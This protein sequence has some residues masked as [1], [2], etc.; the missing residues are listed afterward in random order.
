MREQ[1]NFSPN[2]GTQ[3]EIC[4]IKVIGVGGAGG[5]AVKS[6][7]TEGIVGV[8]FLIC[9]TDK[10]AL[11]SNPVPNKLVLG[12]T[13][14]GAGAK[15]EVACQYAEESIDEIKKLIGDDTKMLFITA[16]MGKGT[17]TGAT[18]VIAKV[19]KEMGILT[20]GVV[21]SPYTWEGRKMLERAENGIAE[22]KKYVDSIIV[23]NNQNIL[24][25]YPDDD[26]PTAYLRVDNVLKTAVK[27][28]AELITV[29]LEQ[30]IDF[31]DIKTIL[32]GSGAAMMGIGESNSEN[33]MEEVFTEAFDCPLL[34]QDKVANARKFL[35]C[36][37][38]GPDRPAKMSE[39]GDLTSRF[40]ELL[41]K[42]VDLIWGRTEDPALGDKVKLSVII[43]DY[44]A[45]TE[46]IKTTD[47]T[48]TQTQEVV[49]NIAPKINANIIINNGPVAGVEV[50]DREVEIEVE[51]PVMETSTTEEEQPT[52]VYQ[53][54]PAA[55]TEVATFEP[56]D[57]QPIEAPLQTDDLDALFDNDDDFTTL[58]TTPAISNTRANTMTQSSH[59]I[60][61]EPKDIY[62]ISMSSSTD[63]SS[64]LF[65]SSL[66]D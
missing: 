57:V 44:E 46:Q 18:P 20:V 41:S 22:L 51:Q 21:T 32:Q 35:F 39:L 65:G 33:R 61:C 53:P 23:V 37:S 42:D 17:G 45:N 31:N 29:N 48:A 11:D 66:A 63:D 7:Y 3:T 8:D 59:V 55:E 49:E 50:I 58:L 6:M 28:I 9:N 52:D 1:T 26:I 12:K 60:T 5:N 19:A 2:Y 47:I 13:G 30:N 24:K 38:Y 16:G 10:K 14:L 40:D 15:P 64:M 27:C 56:Q 62:Q 36:I 25:F 34:A 54:E 4:S 43:T